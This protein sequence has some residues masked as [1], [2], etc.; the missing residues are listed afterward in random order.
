[1]QAGTKDVKEVRAKYG[2]PRNEDP[3]DRY[4]GGALGCHLRLYFTGLHG[5]RQAYGGSHN[6]KISADRRFPV[7]GRKVSE[8]DI[9][10]I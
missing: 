10:Q 6:P 1:M 3:L 5:V 4:S 8:Y 2:L 7:S 9:D